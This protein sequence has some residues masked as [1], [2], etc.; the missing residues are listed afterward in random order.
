MEAPDPEVSRRP[1]GIS[2][3]VRRA[4][5]D[6]YGFDGE[7]ERSVASTTTVCRLRVEGRK[8]GSEDFGLVFITSWRARERI[9]VLSCS[10]FVLLPRVICYARSRNI[11][12]RAWRCACSLIVSRNGSERWLGGSATVKVV[13]S[14]SASFLLCYFFR[15]YFGE[16]GGICSAC[17]TALFL[18]LFFLSFFILSLSL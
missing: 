7:G 17:C 10:C 11:T 1:V 2:R 8:G 13:F 15:G 16:D 9:W 12:T 4:G 3:P 14:D 6:G 5:E 18:R